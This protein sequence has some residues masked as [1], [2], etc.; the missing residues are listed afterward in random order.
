[1]VSILLPISNT[2]DL[3]TTSQ[4]LK[5]LAK[6]VYKD[7]ELLIVT[8]KNSA[9]KI[10]PITKK[11]PF[12]KVFE[13]DL[14]KGAARNLA[15]QKAKGKYIYHLDA[16]MAPAPQVLSECVKKA[17]E[18]AEAI[19]IPD[20]EA[21]Q[22]HF[23]SKC[24]ALERRILYGSRAAYTPIFL[25]KTLFEKSG[26]YD[27]DLDPMDDWN[28]HL[29]LREM[30]VE[31]E[32]IQTP[33]LVKAVTD[34][35]RILKRKYEMGRIYPALKAKHP[36][37]RQL[38]PK[39]RLEDYF[40]NWKEIAKS[41]HFSLGLFFLKLGDI[42]SFFW[43]T[44]HPIEPKNRYTLTKVAEEYEQKRLGNN[45]GRYKHFAELKSLF[46]LLPKKD[47]KILEVGCGTGRVTEQLIKRGYKVSPIDSS[48][49]MLVQYKQKPGLPKPQLTNATQLPF[50]DNSFPTVFSLRVIWHLGNKEDREKMFSEAI[51]VSSNLIILDITNKKR[52]PKI[53]RD[54]YPN[55]YFFTWKEF[56]ELCKE[57]NL[58]IEARIPLD[59]LAPF[60][61]NFFPSN[62]ATAFFPLIYRTDL[63]LAKLIPPGRYLVKL[64]KQI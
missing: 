50:P 4:C 7:F 33:V 30:G 6:Q 9:K 41:P 16:D 56:I 12:I 64:V 23:I 61:L 19:I 49:A 40:R 29:T 18:G 20:E 51:R 39:L 44:L 11:Y 21:P 57:S 58:K 25:K 42:L 46:K 22:A 59:A 34:L 45:F 55:E 5:S 35:R 13:K 3:K 43:G 60:W 52:W 14:G 63:L 36:H 28:L 15:A 8:S 2:E 32:S 24:R 53:Y 17:E 1:M 26:G 54:R 10:S 37:P 38:N 31:F 47:L 27:E 48:Q 62:L